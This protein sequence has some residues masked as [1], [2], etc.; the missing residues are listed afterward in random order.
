MVVLQHVVAPDG[1]AAGRGYSQ[2]VTGRGRLVVVSGQI[3]QD[4][5]GELV[6]ARDPATPSSIP[7]GRLPARPFRWPP[8]SP[9]VTCLRWR[10]GPWPTTDQGR[11]SRVHQE[12]PTPSAG[13]RNRRC[14]DSAHIRSS[15]NHPASCTRQTVVTASFSRTGATRRPQLAV[16]PLGGR[17]A[18]ARRLLAG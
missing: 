1:V 15:P 13:S 9:P 8:C 17:F 10:P 14:S 16:A 6:G 4:E 12:R 11:A 3:A 7:A 2:V 5:H 18:H